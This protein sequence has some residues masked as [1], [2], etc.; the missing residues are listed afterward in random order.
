M[1]LN[2]RM[3][4]NQLAI[5]GLERYKKRMRQ[6]VTDGMHSAALIV[7]NEARKLVIKGPKTGKTY[8]KRG[9]KILHRASAPGE[10][11]ASDT[12]T[13]VRNIIVVPDRAND[14]IRVIAN[15]NYSLYLEQGTRRMKP[16][17]FMIVALFNSIPKIRAVIAAHLKVK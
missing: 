8:L 11:P 3:R 16:R 15:T 4:G 7:Q 9:G 6:Q 13:L 10:P 5:N 14:L 12:G 1:T 17:P 2:V